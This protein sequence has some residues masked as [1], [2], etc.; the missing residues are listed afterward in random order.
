M[1]NMYT[2]GVTC[3]GRKD[4]RI[5]RSIGPFVKLIP[6]IMTRRSDS[7]I[8]TQQLIETDGIDSYLR[9]KRSQGF[10][11]N[12]MHLVIS[13]CVRVIAMRPQLNRFVMSGR[14]YA[15]KGIFVS[16]AVKRSLHDEGEET[17]V[18][19]EFTGKES[20][21]EVADI[22]DTTIRNAA[23][24]N[25]ENDADRIA[26][27]IMALPMPL[28]GIAVAV[29]KTMDKL[30][31]LPSGIIKAS[32]FHTSMFFTHLKSI[33]LDYVYHHLYDIGTTGSFVALGKVKK[34]PVAQGDT[35]AVKNCCEI[36]Y[37][38]DERLCDG[39]YFSNSLKLFRR[40]IEN[41]HMLESSLDRITDDSD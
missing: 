32:P 38:M 22:I 26:K 23:S 33:K 6:Y 11:L 14:I 16:M 15:R 34:M 10:G 9:L 21:F 2:T 7:Q 17:T 1:E 31:I 19:F 30:S 20:I 4:G 37:V 13:A 12:Y 24:R 8:F 39:L 29:M 41:P 40:Y 18:K 25:T 5:I 35:V 3:M 28:V 27:R 36:G